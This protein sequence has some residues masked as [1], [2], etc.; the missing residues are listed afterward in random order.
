MKKINALHFFLMIH[1]NILNGFILRKINSYLTTKLLVNKKEDYHKK[2][3][4]QGLYE[5]IYNNI[6]YKSKFI[7]I[8]Y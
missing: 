3:H 7:Y 8:I 2:M 4:F 1:K 6:N 5:F